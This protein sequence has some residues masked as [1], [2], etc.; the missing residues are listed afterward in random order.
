MLRVWYR[1]GG[2]GWA[3]GDG[4][5]GWDGPCR[6][7]SGETRE[8]AVSFGGCASINCNPCIVPC[9][10]D[11]SASPRLRSL[12]GSQDMWAV[13]ISFSALARL[14]SRDLVSGCELCLLGPH[15]TGY[16]HWSS[17]LRDPLSRCLHGADCVFGNSIG[18]YISGGDDEIVCLRS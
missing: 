4:A 12:P 2:R 5:D 9:T 7:E 8:E 1:L 13:V 11:S 18:L 17:R 14:R 16:F 10:S 15:D 6:R 3:L